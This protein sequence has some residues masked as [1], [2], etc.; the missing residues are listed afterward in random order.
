MDVMETVMGLVAVAAAVLS[1]LVV[2]VDTRVW[3][4]RVNR[5][6]CRHNRGETSR[7]PCSTTTTPPS[8]APWRSSPRMACPMAAMCNRN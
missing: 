7:S 3:T 8:P 1:L 2:V 5:S 4:G 6:A